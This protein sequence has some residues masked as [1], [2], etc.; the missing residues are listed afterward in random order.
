V[1]DKIGTTNPWIHVVPTSSS[2]DRYPARL[3]ELISDINMKILF[4]KVDTH[5]GIMPKVF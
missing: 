3:T 1:L 4:F 5:V 2:P